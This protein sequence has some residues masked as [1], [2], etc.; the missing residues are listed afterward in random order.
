M[1]QHSQRSWS[2]VP[3]SK[4]GPPFHP[5]VVPCLPSVPVH[6]TSSVPVRVRRGN[7]SDAPPPGASRSGP[8]GAVVRRHTRTGPSTSTSSPVERRSPR[9]PTTGVT[10]HS[11]TGRDERLG[12][13]TEG[14]PPDVLWSPSF[15]SHLPVPTT[16]LHTPLDPVPS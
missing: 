11:P 8:S 14:A 12:R 1:S 16:P 5:S 10:S 6:G 7:R 13:V 2:G 3:R 4:M 15:H 9:D